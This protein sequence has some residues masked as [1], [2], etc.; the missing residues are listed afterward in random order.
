MAAIEREHWE[1]EASALIQ[2]SARELFSHGA[3]DPNRSNCPPSSGLSTS[4]VLFCQRG[5]AGCGGGL[6]A[7]HGAGL[8]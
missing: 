1:D 8:G 5:A 6:A 3:A 2:L 4:L 7:D